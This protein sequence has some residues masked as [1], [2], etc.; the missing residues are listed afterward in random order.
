MRLFNSGLLAALLI[1]SLSAAS[2]QTL[3]TDTWTGAV[4]TAWATPGNWSAGRVPLSTDDVLINGP[5]LALFNPYVTSVVNAHHLTLAAGAV[6]YLENTGTLLLG[7]DFTNLSG[8][9]LGRGRGTLS[10]VGTSVQHLNGPASTSFRNLR[11]GAAGAITA[12]P[13]A[14]ERGLTVYGLLTIGTNQP[15][16]V[17]STAT[18]PGYVV[19]AGGSVSGPVSV[20]RYIDPG[21]NPALGYRHLS[22]PVTTATFATL[23]GPGYTP[24]FNTAYNTAADPG[25]TRPYPTVYGYDQSRLVSQAAAI[26]PSP[27]NRGFYS[28][29]AT[30]PMVQGYGYTVNLPGAVNGAIAVSLIGEPLFFVKQL[31]FPLYTVYI[32]PNV[33]IAGGVL[34]WVYPPPFNPYQANVA[35]RIFYGFY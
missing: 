26:S 1:G 10:L 7:G 8:S 34:S 30:D 19:N 9:V 20:Q 14:V 29:V 28:P 2:A 5:S 24:V 4:S 21:F 22:S 15:F 18:G 31:S 11:V 27:F 16:T 25:T 35:V 12:A 23:Q 6:L 3:P 32:F 17:L 33:S 13:V